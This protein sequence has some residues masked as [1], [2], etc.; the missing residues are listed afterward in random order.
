[1]GKEGDLWDDS[2]LTRAFD[3]AIS[4]YKK[5]HS[6]KGR[7]ASI[8]REM[9]V[10]STG[11]N[12][13]ANVNESLEAGRDADEKNNASA[14]TATDLG[15]TNLLLVKEN[16]NVDSHAPEPC[17]DS[18]NSLQ[19]QDVE[20]AGKGYSS[21]HNVEDY[22]EVL[23]Q[24]YE[25]EEKRQKILEQLYQF[26]G[27]NNQ[28]SVEGSV[29]AVQWGGS[30]TH[31]ECPVPASQMSHSNAFCSCCPYVSQCC[32]VPCTSCPGCSL[33]GTYV[34]KT[35]SDNSVVT[36]AG[37]S[38]LLKD[39]NIVKTA[40]GAAEKAISSMM[41]KVSGDS[42]INEEQE[43][44]KTEGETSQSPISKT[45]LTDVLNAW[46]SA[47]FYTGKYLTEQSIAKKHG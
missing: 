2:A 42:N 29:P 15:E 10:S 3:D 46:Y 33:G 18:L 12:A 38:G 16:S 4:N 8:E 32:N 40:M 39:G 25:L 34:G 14:N 13:S 23:N 35:C 43:R 31:Q 1:M 28:Y 22:N 37:S 26:G 19:K 20:S 44:A 5:M 11:E 30:S 45:D 24:Y 47:G 17:I 9:D 27:W 41:T 36:V 6:K 21:F 7:D